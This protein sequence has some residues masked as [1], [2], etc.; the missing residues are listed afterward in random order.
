MRDGNQPPRPEERSFCN[1]SSLLFYGRDGR[2]GHFRA[3]T[4]TPLVLGV[5]ITVLPRRYPFYGFPWYPQ[6][7]LTVTFVSDACEEVYYQK[8]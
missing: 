4:G 3:V 5:R 8:R 6:K 2:Y 7:Q 1:I